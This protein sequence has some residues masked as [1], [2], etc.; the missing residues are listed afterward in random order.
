[1]TYKWDFS[2]L[3]NYR[4]VLAEGLLNTVYLSL[5]VL[6]CGLVL[7][8]V[9]AA[10]RISRFATLRAVGSV[11]VELFRNV[12]ALVLLFW[13]FYTIP[14]L[15]GIQ[16]GRFLTAAVA[17]SLYSGAYFCEIL[18][19][20]IQSIDR[21]QWEAS[22]ALG[23]T[24]RTVFGSIILPQAIRRTLPALTNEAIE[25][26]KISAVAATIAYPDALYQAKL[27]SDTEYR[28]VEVYTVIAV[29][30]TAIIL[31]LSGLSY[32]LEY[33]FSKSN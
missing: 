22:I 16:N 28:P 19:G 14:V 18:R 17:F 15:T 5:T 1:M 12:P 26:F 23:M 25:V 24:F 30:L 3:W 27:I 31:V 4:H 6:A 20:G 32:A 13:F 29:L 7:G 9:L 11:Y 21:G 10:A 8:A 33:K 2:F